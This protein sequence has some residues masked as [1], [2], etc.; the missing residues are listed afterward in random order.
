[1]QIERDVLPALHPR[2]D[3]VDGLGIVGAQ[4]FERLFG[5]HHAKPPGRALG[6]LFEQIDLRVRMTPFPEIGEVETAGASTDDGDAHVFLPIDSILTNL[7]WRLICA[8]NLRYRKMI[9]GRRSVRSRPC[10]DRAPMAGLRRQFY[11]RTVVRSA[12]LA[13]GRRIDLPTKRP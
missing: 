8:G 5:E 10:Q 3:G 4:K 13:S 9:R 1:M 11:P 6:V 7:E 2:C 12:V